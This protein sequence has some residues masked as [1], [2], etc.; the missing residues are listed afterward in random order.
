MPTIKQKRALMKVVENGGNITKAMKDVGYSLA[1]VNNPDV[2]TSSKG[3]QELLNEFLPDGILLKTELEGL[4]ATKIITSGAEPN[5][6]VPDH[7]TRH[8]YLE[9]GLKI[10]GKIKD[11]STTE[12]KMLILRLDV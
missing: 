9:T 4:G 6:E 10:K 3:W 7:P 8:K 11:E 1:T 12:V 5:I 2:L